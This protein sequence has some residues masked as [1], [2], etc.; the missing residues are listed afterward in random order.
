[1]AEKTT[2]QRGK[3]ARNKG[4]SGELEVAHLLWKHGFTDA[5]RTQQ[6]SGKDGTADVIGL[7]GFHIEVKR[8]EVL[9][10]EKWCEQ[11]TNDAAAGNVP[12]V[13]FRRSHQPWRVVLDFDQFLN[14]V[15]LYENA[16]QEMD[17]LDDLRAKLDE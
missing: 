8:Q 3:A 14:F 17:E 11:A 5:H 9:R 10:I 2:A 6:F 7:P 16:M 4:K 12:I 1:M 15:A 13:V